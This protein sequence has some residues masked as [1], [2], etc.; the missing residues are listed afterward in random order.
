MKVNKSRKSTHAIMAHG[1]D[2]SELSII[3][4]N[5][6]IVVP[7]YYMFNDGRLK[8]KY[9]DVINKAFAKFNEEN[10]VQVVINISHLTGDNTRALNLIKEGELLAE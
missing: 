9:V 3:R 10:D 1:G 7:K 2:F 4:D 5:V 8:K 6:K